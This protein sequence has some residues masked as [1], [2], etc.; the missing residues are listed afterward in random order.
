MTKHVVLVT[1]GFPANE[2]DSAAVP[3]LQDYCRHL[4]AEIGAENITVLTTQYPFTRTPYQWKGIQVLPAGGANKK[5]FGY[6]L[7][8]W[9]TQ[10]L[11]RSACTDPNTVVHAFWLTDAAMH[12]ARVARKKN[13]P[14]IVTLM[15][16]DVNPGN[17]WFSLMHAD[18]RYVALSE[19]QKEQFLQ[20]YHTP[21]EAVIPF[22]LPDITAAY[23]IHRTI[24]LLFI[25]SYIAVKRPLQFIEIVHEIRQLHPGIRA[26][27]IG[28]GPLQ[29]EMEAKMQELGL[30]HNLIIHPMMSREHVLST[31]QHARI[32]VHTS[33]S[34]GQC[35]VYGE[36]L[37]SG[38]HVLSYAVG[39]ITAT[40]KHQVC[41]DK[42]DFVLKAMELLARPINFTPVQT[43]DARASIDAYLALYEMPISR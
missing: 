15:G 33:A 38:M 21:V 7:L 43:V 5:G 18:V 8:L 12:A 32:L 24:D 2:Q 3:Y 42:R 36:A 26:V 39:N 27:M 35:L 11:L 30:E 6:P 16:Q 13:L 23:H 25:G 41:N 40:P 29:A 1:P 28:G 34:E 19:Q 22:P 4:S 10:R 14:C 31:M 20:Q 9:R 37:L 17:R